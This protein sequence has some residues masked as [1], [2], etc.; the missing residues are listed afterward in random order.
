MTDTMTLYLTCFPHL[1]KRDLK[2]VGHLMMTMLT[3]VT[4]IS[5]LISVLRDILQL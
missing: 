3:M 1:I 5:N 2:S 4:G